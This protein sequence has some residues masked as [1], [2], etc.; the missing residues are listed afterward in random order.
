MNEASERKRVRPVILSGGSGTRLWPLSRLGRPK[1]LIAL[2]EGEETMLQQAARR[3]SD[4]ASFA[5]PLIVASQDHAEAIEQ[6]LA[7][8]GID[9]ATLAVEAAPRNTAAAI[10]LAA[11]LSSPDALLLVMPSDHAIGDPHAFRAAIAAA[12][13]FAEDGWLVTF[14]VTPDRPETGY[15][16]IQA[17]EEIGARVRRAAAFAE[18]PDAATAAAYLAAG[19][20][21]W[22][23]G[24][25]L[26][27]ADSC[28]AALG[29][30]APDLLRVLEAAV[31]G[32]TQQGARLHPE[33]AAF[34]AAPS[35][36]FDKAVMERA[37]RVA[38]VPVDMGWSDIG[39]W[40]AVHALGPWDE[41]GNARHGDVVAP[42]SQG[43]LI[44]SDGPT[45]VALGVSD[46]VI[47][48][49]ERAVL[50]VPRG[51]TQR[52]KEAIDALEARRKAPPTA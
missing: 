24:I 9:G 16:Y 15:G 38:V 17:G 31:A 8:I 18:K 42:G 41:A 51:E 39:S 45:V 48:A 11:L 46:L 52:V 32:Q 26:M 36:S 25:F 3:V 27:R 47:V 2:V 33:P 12:L 4:A 14:G 23:A 34:A 1:Q 20:R 49:T 28:T 43:C 5:P 10:G 7:A 22:N 37:D 6:Q 44:R 19:D 29:A 40:E 13:P 21:L 50:V 35:L 30:F